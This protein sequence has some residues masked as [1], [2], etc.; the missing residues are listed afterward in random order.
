MPH[1][2]TLLCLAILALPGALEA[3]DTTRPAPKPRR[4]PD[5]ISTQEIE[6]ASESMRNAYELVKGL[7]SNWLSIR[8]GSSLIRG[9]SVVKVY[10]DGVRRGGPETLEQ[11]PKSSIKEMQRLRGTDATQRF[12]VDHE[13]GAILVIS[14]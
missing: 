7:R 12:G 6:A 4:N 2:R 13:N 3:Q 9:S 14:R 10:V 1:L 5:L 11:I 8:G